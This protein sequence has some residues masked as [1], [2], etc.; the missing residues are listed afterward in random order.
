MMD[1]TEYEK[2]NSVLNLNLILTWR[3]EGLL[4]II[5]VVVGSFWA[6]ISFCS[7]KSEKLLQSQ[8]SAMCHS[9]F[10]HTKIQRHRPQQISKL[11]D[12]VTHCHSI[13]CQCKIPLPGVSTP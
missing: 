12:I 11:W 6:D 8:F 10:V 3:I 5:I 2:M 13:Q 7:K 9:Q 4:L 1:L